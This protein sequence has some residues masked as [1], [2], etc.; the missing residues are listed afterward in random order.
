MPDQ[1]SDGQT[2]RQTDCAFT[3]CSVAAS[4]VAGRRVVQPGVVADGPVPDGEGPHLLLLS[5]HLLHHQHNVYSV[6]PKK[7]QP[8]NV[9]SF[10]EFYFIEV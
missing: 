4:H 5:A 2:N 8:K 3:C 9:I 6:I 10:I 1:P 7:R